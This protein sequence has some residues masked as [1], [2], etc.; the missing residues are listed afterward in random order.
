MQDSK[1]TEKCFE[2]ISLLS[3][4]DTS[5][6]ND[7]INCAKYHPKDEIRKKSTLAL[8]NTGNKD[9]LPLLLEMYE[10]RRMYYTE[11]E[12]LYS[13]YKIVD[14]EE[15]RKLKEIML[16]N[17]LIYSKDAV[18]EFPELKKD[19]ISMIIDRIENEVNHRDII[20][21]LKLLCMIDKKETIKIAT[22]CLF[23]SDYP[24]ADKVRKTAA[25]ILE[26]FDSIPS[27]GSDEL[28][29]LAIKEDWEEII[30]RGDEALFFL[31]DL[32]KGDWLYSIPKGLF[33]FGEKGIEILLDHMVE[34]RFPTPVI[35][36]LLNN[37]EEEK[38]QK[39]LTESLLK[40]LHHD[41]NV[42]RK[43]GSLKVLD[44]LKWQPTNEKEID[45]KEF[46]NYKSINDNIS[47]INSVGE[48]SSFIANLSRS[49]CSNYLEKIEE[50]DDSRI[51]SLLLAIFCRIPE[52]SFQKVEK[53]LKKFKW[54]PRIN[55]EAFYLDFLAFLS[56]PLEYDWKVLPNYGEITLKPL[57]SYASELC[58]ILEIFFDDYDEYYDYY[59][60]EDIIKSEDHNEINSICFTIIPQL[61]AS[62]GKT[63]PKLVDKYKLLEWKYLS[64]HETILMMQIVHYLDDKRALK[65]LVEIYNYSEY[66]DEKY[67]AETILEG[68]GWDFKS[69][70]KEKENNEIKVRRIVEKYISEES[71]RRISKL[72][73]IE[74]YYYQTI[75]SSISTDEY[76]EEFAKESMMEAKEYYLNKLI[77]DKTEYALDFFLLL[78]LDI[79]SSTELNYFTIDMIGEFKDK[80]AIE[81]LQYFIE[82]ISDSY[83]HEHVN[84][85]MNDLK[86][87]LTVQTFFKSSSQLESG[88]KSEDDLIYLFRNNSSEEFVK[89]FLKNFRSDKITIINFFL[90]NIKQISNL[91]VLEIALNV[92]EQCIDGLKRESIG[93]SENLDPKII[94]QI[95]SQILNKE[96]DLFIHPSN[97]N[98]LKNLQLIVSKIILR[99]NQEDCIKLLLK[100][101]DTHELYIHS[102]DLVEIVSEVLV[103]K[104]SADTSES[105][106][107]MIKDVSESL[108][109]LIIDVLGDIADNRIVPN[110]IRLYNETTLNNLRLRIIKSMSFFEDERLLKPLLTALEEDIS[111]ELKCIVISLLGTKEY[112]PNEEII[113]FMEKYY[114]Q[115]PIR[116]KRDIVYAIGSA[117]NKRVHDILLDALKQPD[118]KV[119]NAAASQIIHNP[120]VEA[121]NPLLE[122][123]N[124]SKKSI[125][126]SAAA[127]GRL[128]N[129]EAIPHLLD[130][131]EKSNDFG[132]LM[133]IES[134]LLRLCDK[135]NVHDLIQIL[136][137]CTNKK[138]LE[139]LTEVLGKIGDDRAVPVLVRLKEKY[140][141]NNE[142]KNIINK[143]I[144]KLKS[145]QKDKTKNNIKK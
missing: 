121:Y 58:Y 123:L 20:R 57:L 66:N 42:V 36:V 13:I 76:M 125:Q 43:K 37:F 126:Y 52:K 131:F 97:G 144:R 14:N 95:T 71:M 113:S 87:D 129:K 102:S 28:L 29:Y 4:G 135:D 22:K 90:K 53:I 35:G 103:G 23:H 56:K 85:V 21:N 33:L 83:F 10:L 32:L 30:N 12:A 68:L 137:R 140:E 142:M 115:A 11:S 84:K 78:L 72:K 132:S 25:E 119:Q 93:F 50:S 17:T 45:L 138:H 41:K 111:D 73:E 116:V 55:E 99:I 51:I 26:N 70:E 106:L 107:E 79:R 128:G 108:Q 98:S 69:F 6:F 124:T 61:I 110:L 105:L 89:E 120:I 94:S 47:L 109:F 141:T 130:L 74:K 27:E 34:R 18:T 88:L 77:R 104:N 75:N 91:E 133:G 101:L 67:L 16:S 24:N 139:I 38:L 96:F 2:N 118:D 46:L 82:N 5:K 136:E 117:K 114:Y 9:I 62:V 49:E 65:Q 59:E 54:K 86:G 40:V 3:E 92:F 143:T 39:S 64:K 112:I 48:A 134:A 81:P 80:R 145:T 8:G 127:L 31:K 63:N 19:I 60:E 15:K 7:V 44:F 100:R 1:N 122:L